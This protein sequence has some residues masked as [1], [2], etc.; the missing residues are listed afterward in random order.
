MRNKLFEKFE[1]LTWIHPAYDKQL[2]HLHLSSHHH[3]LCPTVFQSKPLPYLHTGHF[4]SPHALAY[5]QLKL[6]KV[7]PVIWKYQL[8]FE[9]SISSEVKFCYQDDYNQR[10]TSNTS[11]FISIQTSSNVCLCLGVSCL[12][13]YDIDIVYQYI[14][15][16][17]RCIVNIDKLQRNLI[18]LTLVRTELSLLSNLIIWQITFQEICCYKNM[19][20]TGLRNL[21]SCWLT[22]PLLKCLI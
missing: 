19:Y 7:L 22:D 10:S 20:F 21:L 17:I 1:K 13:Q 14:V 2:L 15:R 8:D 12:S 16:S 3:K 5:L 11:S 4:H 6:K 18:C 9:P